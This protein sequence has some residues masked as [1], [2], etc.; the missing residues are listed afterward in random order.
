MHSYEESCSLIDRIVGRC[1]REAE[2]ASLVLSDPEAALKD[3]DLNEDELD[4]FRALRAD[5]AA[6]AGEAWEEI[7]E[8]IGELQSQHER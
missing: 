3:Y 2:F 7:R 4:D 8:R 1:V 6:E 5:H